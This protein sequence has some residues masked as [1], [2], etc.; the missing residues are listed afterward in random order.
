M[1]Q[2]S[3]VLLFTGL[4]LSAAA[5]LLITQHD[6]NSPFKP[7]SSDGS[8]TLR[9]TTQ[10]I[11]H[12]GSES[13][14]IQSNDNSP[15]DNASNDFYQHQQALFELL[16]RDAYP[17]AAN[18][19]NEHY[20]DLSTRELDLL[21]L[22]FYRRASS[23]VKNKQYQ[24]LIDLFKSEVSVYDDLDAWQGLSQA[25][26]D[27][28][29]WKT[30]F[31]ATLKTSSL[32]SD[33]THLTHLQES[34]V[35]IAGYRRQ[36]LENEQDQLSIL[37]MYESLYAAHPGYPRFQLEL[38]YAHLRLDQLEQAKS[39]LQ[40]LR[41]D[42]ELG[43]ISQDVLTKIEQRQ[44]LAT[45]GNLANEETKAPIDY[46]YRIPLRRIGTSLLANIVINNQSVP[47]LL[48][49]G[50]SITALDQRLIER[51][52]L[53]PTNQRIQISTANGV[54][55]AQLYRVKTLKL[56][57]YKLNNVIVAGIELNTKGAFSG[58]L[59][60][61][62]LNAAA[63]QSSYVIDNAQGALIFQR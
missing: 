59:G 46:G 14:P 62:I 4:C 6:T 2:K 23:L 49:T 38:A 13:G 56:G 9:N 63:P 19:L 53:P 17:A 36:A 37:S 1:M 24:T 16:E 30:A 45:E 55:N 57:R 21:R 54:R 20:S 61:D 12:K 43:E 51:L 29:S 40:V 28:K 44:A 52:N 33:G 31:D 18:Y 58:L 35:S 8:V 22:S 41:Y 25:A 27:A 48:D 47:M 5:W 42:P 60:T 7:L 50:A 26:I 15:S 11:G 32:A 10:S 39:Y 3:I 34:L